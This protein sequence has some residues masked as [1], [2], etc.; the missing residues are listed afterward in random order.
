MAIRA[1]F[2][3]YDFGLFG[4]IYGGGTRLSRLHRKMLK[5]WIGVE[6][7]SAP[8]VQKIQFYGDC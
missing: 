8:S 3:A 1:C 7:I 5:P 2:S 6:G 4:T